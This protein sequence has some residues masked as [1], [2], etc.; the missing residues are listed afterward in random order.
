[1][2]GWAACSWEARGMWCM[3]PVSSWATTTPAQTRIAEILEPSPPT[4][5]VDPTCRTT[6]LLKRMRGREEEMRDEWREE[7][8]KDEW[9]EQVPCNRGRNVGVG[10]EGFVVGGDEYSPVT[11]IPHHFGGLGGEGRDG[12][13]IVIK[14]I[15]AKR[16]WR[17]GRGEGEQKWNKK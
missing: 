4:R 17:E 16:R 14:M 2:F 6:G 5:I 1:M 13:L 8:M 3:M 15:K 7:E 9:R 11:C 12:Y 10:V